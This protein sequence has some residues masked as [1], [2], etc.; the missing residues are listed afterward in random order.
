MRALWLLILLAQIVMM[1][2]QAAR[3]ELAKF[4]V[5][6]NS[7]SRTYKFDEPRKVAAL[8]QQ[9]GTNQFVLAGHPSV[10]WWEWSTDGAQWTRL[11]NTTLTNDNRLLRLHQL[12]KSITTRYLRLRFDQGDALGEAAFDN[13]RPPREDLP[14]SVLIVNST[15]D[16]TLPNHGQEFFP[17]LK[18]IPDWESTRAQ[19]VWVRDF[20]PALVEAEPRPLAVFFSGSFK[21]WC[22]VDRSHWRGVEQVLKKAKVPIWAS[23]GGAQ[24]LAILAE[25]GADK[26]WDCPHCRDPK[27][28][29]TPIY[30]HIGHIEAKPCGDYSGCIFERGPQNVR[31]A[32]QDPIFEG[33]PS[34]FKVMQSHC[35]QIAWPPRGWELIATAGAG[36]LTKVQCIKR[37][38]APIY[39]AQ[40]HIEMEGTPDSSKQIMKNFLEQ[41]ELWQR[42]H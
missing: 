6:Q 14:R 8:L 10:S 16:S 34:E 15:H 2:A 18:S 40:F 21:D 32:N 37:K 39:A 25:S 9:N 38:G 27:S 23:C 28:P 20:D 29:K 3:L 4:L 1:S 30:T 42:S 26:P 31:I 36:A 17:L 24:A 5:Q 7:E 12:R 11:S 33:L 13:S 22:E 41:A 35:G 19:Q